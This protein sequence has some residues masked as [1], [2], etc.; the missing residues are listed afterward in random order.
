MEDTGMPIAEA[1]AS[2]ALKVAAA[3]I[4]SYLKSAEERKRDNLYSLEKYVSAARDAIIALEAE[5]DQILV[6]A[7]F[8]DLCSHDDA[9]KLQDRITSYLTVDV[10]SPLL[11]SAALGLRRVRNQL[12]NNAE[13]FFNEWLHPDR[14]PAVF[15]L[16]RVIEHLEEYI[17]NLKGQVPGY[18]RSGVG[19][20]HLNNILQVLEK[21]QENPDEVEANVLALRVKE[22]RRDRSKDGLAF[23]KAGIEKAYFDILDTF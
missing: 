5:Y 11:D 20:H 1:A 10:V 4:G 17:Y 2:T 14:L 7:E 12:H 3:R 23:H 13:G 6:D 15:E 21:Y 9:K 8:C 18:P 22:F 16:T 19:M